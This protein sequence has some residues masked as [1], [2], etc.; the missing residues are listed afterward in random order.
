MDPVLQNKRRPR[1]PVATVFLVLMLTLATLGALDWLLVLE[2]R[3]RSEAQTTARALAHAQARGLQPIIGS[4]SRQPDVQAVKAALSEMLILTDANTERPFF[5]A[6]SVDFG[7]PWES[8]SFAMSDD[9]CSDC[10]TNEI[11]LFD[12][13]T[14]DLVAL[15]HVK[16]SPVF[17]QAMRDDMR[18]SFLIWSAGLL[19]LMSL[20]WWALSLFQSHSDESDVRAAAIFNTSPIP[21][22]LISRPAGTI[23]DTNAS[24]THMFDAV[25]LT[26]SRISDL[27]DHDAFLQLMAVEPD[28][29][30]AFETQ[31]HLTGRDLPVKAT[32]TALTL[33]ER[34]LLV[35]GLID[36][37]EEK[38][39][40]KR[41]AAEK[42]KAD[43]ASR[44]KSTFLAAMSHEIRTPLNGIL[45]FT[46]VLANGN[47]N[48]DQK[49]HL[50]L[51][52]LSARNLLGVIEEVLDFS[53]IEAGKFSVR[54]S[55]VDLAL[56][57]DDTIR[58]FRVK[59][60][61]KGLELVYKEDSALPSAI[62]TD[63]LRL[64]QLLGILIDNA[65]KF[66]PRGGLD[67]ETDIDRKQSEPCLIF[68]VR[69]TGI[70]V[71]ES[72][73]PKLFEPFYQV[74]Q[75]SR[76]PFGGTGLGLV[77]ARN[78]A[79]SLGGSIDVNSQEG[80]GSC[81]TVMLPLSISDQPAPRP[82]R[83]PRRRVSAS[84][85]NNRALVVDDD[86][87]NGKLLVYLLQARNVIAERVESGSLALR[88][89]EHATYDMVFLDLHMPG[90]TGWDV[91][92]ELQK[93]QINGKR[94]YPPL[95]ATTADVQK[96]SR[97]R[98]LADG[99]DDFLAKP[100]EAT[101]LDDIIERW[102]PET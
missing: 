24:A 39:F 45:G 66:T 47:L 60:E 68:R 78:I 99:M 15:L 33:D 1:S 50:E 85:T 4:R 23:I 29:R 46:Q 37:T 35:V 72:E 65:I 94:S 74:D 86:P 20:G 54:E 62:N 21:L 95:I 91:L 58:L 71:A 5:S 101:A 64:R 81:F 75:T 87:I 44:A 22:L 6:I 55:S 57:L 13:N 2:P 84:A 73:L 53:R 41:L 92:E 90:L 11:P 3:L 34:E 40:E 16:S 7:P 61:S 82:S 59:A 8:A 14:G 12:Q 30:L 89:I 97:E 10:F 83:Q 32:A 25:P 48:Q 28:T 9:S 43:A 102:S 93:R 49:E 31:L 17:Y 69:D 79:E 56:L 63:G 27:L 67:V 80:H 100:V 70:G 38:A 76:R 96:D 26:Y 51:I 77:I 18:A 52:D 42:E 98:L 36:I 88:Q 19:A